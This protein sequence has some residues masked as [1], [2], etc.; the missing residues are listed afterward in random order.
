M[1]DDSL[2]G[3]SRRRFTRLGLGAGFGVLAAGCTRSAADAVSGND[4]VIAQAATEPPA[5]LA[6]TSSI[7]GRQLLGVK[8]AG[9]K[10]RVSGF[11]SRNWADYFTTL[12]DGAILVDT[13][14]RILHFWSAKHDVYNI[15]PASVPLSPELTRTGRT[16]VIRK[17]EGPDWRPTPN[18]LKRD[19]TLPAYVGPGPQNP[20]GTHALY[21]SWTYY[22]IHGTNDE[23]KIGRKSS[24]GCI[25]LYNE[26]IQEV[27]G[28]AEVGTRVLIV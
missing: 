13:P 12:D 15:Y 11:Q 21:L 5:Q 7:D 6:A 8:E 9:L 3:L 16:S 19:P 2:S 4:A 26:H 17:R 1:T 25:G 28:M 20:L 23:R 22:R 18:M 14:A 10:R 27:F 24:N